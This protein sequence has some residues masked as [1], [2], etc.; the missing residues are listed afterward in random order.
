MLGPSIGSPMAAVFI[1]NPLLYISVS[2]M[3]SAPP[4][5]AFGDER[6]KVLE[7]ALW[8]LPDDSVLYPRQLERHAPDFI[9]AHVGP[10]GYHSLRG[11][12]RPR[13]PYHSLRGPFR[14]RRPARG[15]R[16]E[17]SAARCA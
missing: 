16:Q 1:E 12:F 3:S 14:P 9:F 13:R 8:L 6:S 17:R 11:P 10:Q 7:V 5:A 2:A 15:A 4:S